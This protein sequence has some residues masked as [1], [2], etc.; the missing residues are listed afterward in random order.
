MCCFSYDYLSSKTSENLLGRDPVNIAVPA[1]GKGGAIFPPSF[2]DLG[3]IQ[4]FWAKSKLK[5][6]KMPFF[7]RDYH[8]FKT[9]FLL[10]PR[11]LDKFF[12]LFIKY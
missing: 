1:G 6:G 12:V 7:F 10:R 4:I 5:L 9:K 11:I 2:Q 3:K 8:D